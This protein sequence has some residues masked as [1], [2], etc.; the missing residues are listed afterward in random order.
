MRE[1]AVEFKHGKLIAGEVNYIHRV[2]V[3]AGEY[4]VG[5]VLE[6]TDGL[7]Y[8]KA[9]TDASLTKEYAVVAEAVKLEVSGEVVCYKEGYFNKNVTKINSK[10]AS[11]NSIEILKTKRIFITTVKED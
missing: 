10:T 7:T 4:N 2:K 6:T 11:D 1:S 9:T 8:A 3:S 5:D